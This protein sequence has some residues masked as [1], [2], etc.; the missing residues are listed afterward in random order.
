MRRAQSVTAYLHATSN[1]P[2]TNILTPAAM[3]ETGTSSNQTPQGR[4]E[5]RRVEVKVLINRGLAGKQ[6]KQ[7]ETTN[8]SRR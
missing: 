8:I 7:D 4:A 3:G 6:L 1:I 2:L 5:N